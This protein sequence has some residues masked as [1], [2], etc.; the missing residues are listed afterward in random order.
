MQPR[1]ALQP[2]TILKLNFQNVVRKLT[3]E[4]L[5]GEGGSCLV[6]K[7]RSMETDS[8]MILKEFYP[9]YEGYAIK[10]E[11]TVI[12]VSEPTKKNTG[13]CRMQ[14]YFRSNY[15]RMKE[16]GN[17]EETQASN[18]TVKIIPEGFAEDNGTM[19]ILQE[20]NKGKKFE[21]MTENYSLQK[22]IGILHLVA[23]ALSQ[24][25]ALG[26]LHLDVKPENV[27]LLDGI[28]DYIKL[29]DFD[30]MVSKAELEEIGC[31][32]RSSRDYPAPELA[33]AMEADAYDVDLDETTDFYSLGA[34][35]FHKVTGE[36]FGEKI[37][38]ISNYPKG[39]SQWMDLLE[40][41]EGIG[42][43]DP[44]LRRK[45][46][47]F[48][49]KTMNA[50]K[51]LRYRTGK[52][53]CDALKEL[54]KLAESG[55]YYLKNDI[56]RAGKTFLGREKQLQEIENVLEKPEEKSVVLYGMGGIGKS[57]LA[58]QYVATREKQDFHIIISDYQTGLKEMIEDIYNTHV[59]RTN[60]EHFEMRMATY[61]EKCRFL[62]EL[63]STR[64]VLLI[65]DNF[66]INQ[67]ELKSLEEREILKPFLNMGWKMIL[68][69]R[70]RLTGYG[71]V[72]EVKPLEELEEMF[73]TYYR[74]A[75]KKGN[76]VFT[77][78]ERETLKLLLKEIGYHTLTAELLAK[79]AGRLRKP[80]KD[81]LED[82]QM[83]KRDKNCYRAD[84]VRDDL[85]ESNSLNGALNDIFNI[86]REKD[87]GYI[88]EI[89]IELLRNLSLLSMPITEEKLFEMMG[90]DKDLYEGKLALL[91]DKGWLQ[92]E[93]DWV[94]DDE[95]Y[96]RMHPVVEE[97]VYREFNDDITMEKCGR[98]VEALLNELKEKEVNLFIDAEEIRNKN[99]VY[100]TA[101]KKLCND[102]QCTSEIKSKLYHMGGIWNSSCQNAN[103]A[104]CFL[105]KEMNC[106]G[107][108]VKN[109]RNREW[110]EADIAWIDK[111]ISLE[112]KLKIFRSAAQQGYKYAWFYLGYNFYYYE[113]NEEKAIECLNM[114]VELGVA[115]AMYTLGNVEVI[116]DVKRE[117]RISGEW[118]MQAAK[119]GHIVSQHNVGG[120]YKCGDGVEQNEKEAFEWYI[121]AAKGG[122]AIAQYAVGDA[123]RR[124]EG[125][126]KSVENAF[127][128]YMRAAKN[129][130]NAAQF[131]L[132]EIYEYGWGEI[133]EQD[134]KEAFEWYMKAAKGGLAIAEYKVGCAY[135]IGQGIEQNVEVA[136]EWYI[137][138]A[139]GSL[140]LAKYKVA[141]AYEFGVGVNQNLQKALLW[142]KDAAEWQYKPA[143]EALKRLEQAIT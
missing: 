49:D 8:L 94:Y 38:R 65:V 124:G 120:L 27:Y 59:F 123:Y 105:E 96:Y 33:R 110:I 77:E 46:A 80:L 128:W 41:A 138:A 125:I 131:F 111:N 47:V 26:Y 102:L 19:Y 90:V 88:D 11:G 56:C 93:E 73:E 113:G 133:I 58:R 82:I 42:G 112:D 81:M 53:I 62:K 121:K 135:E 143:I 100:L 32:V 16:F 109:E 103:E 92:I 5:E 61:E 136:F 18:C 23:D 31:P 45:L 37:K 63:V 57:V 55:R 1:E 114:A 48:F 130:W 84:Y 66:N 2:G 10:R 87:K 39:K 70:S 29:F 24:Y 134:E 79:T 101:L 129:G 140:W 142:Y 34:I 116:S 54:E 97:T 13:F 44:I 6:Y 75:D 28:T 86:F 64:N 76:K 118:Y 115:E 127:E 141:Y 119:L 107:K 35:L 30:T 36:R 122:L 74:R 25:H 9:A 3:I 51:L 4:S 137:R 22:T 52:E 15:D 78:E 117:V 95:I 40:D 43:L 83:G 71:Q 60:P 69:S 91:E 89:E 67:S 7:V 17:N 132:G 104:I 85:P 21:P 68:T 99:C 72:I 108:G 98:I 14:N 12:R 106:I 20:W 126:E 139:K 50:A